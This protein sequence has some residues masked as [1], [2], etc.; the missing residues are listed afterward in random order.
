MSVLIFLQGVFFPSL[1]NLVAKWAPPQEKGKFVAALLGGAFGTVITWPLAGALMESF[2]WAW[3]FY[4]PAIITLIACAFWMVLV[5]DSPSVHP[6][7]TT[8][9]RDYIAKC[10]GD[11][12][13]NKK[14]N[15]TI[16][17]NP[18]IGMITVFFS[19]CACCRLWLR[20]SRWPHPFHSCHS[21]CC[22]MVICGACTS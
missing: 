2:G 3:A 11:T 6:R 7:I 8:D 9:E 14:V 22:I 18:H 16:I 13:S 4:V 17:R 21:C 1:H 20:T 10:M 12:V 15:A 5:A 19:R